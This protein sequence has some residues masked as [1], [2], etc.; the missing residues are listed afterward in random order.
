MPTQKEAAYTPTGLLAVGPVAGG[1]AWGMRKVV[2]TEVI[3]ALLVLLL[4]EEE[5]E[6]RVRMAPP[7]VDS[8][9]VAERRW[10]LEEEGAE[11]EKVW[12]RRY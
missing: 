4:L 11:E 3:R 5:E 8:V 9:L 6:G 1:W 12:S 10:A 2:C 7:L